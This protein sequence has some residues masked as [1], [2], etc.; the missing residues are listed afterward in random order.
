MLIPPSP[1]RDP[2]AL[3]AYHDLIRGWCFAEDLESLEHAGSELLSML[4]GND[5]VGADQHSIR[6]S[7]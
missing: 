5:K 6:L 1:F 3:N 4:I 2:F 7:C